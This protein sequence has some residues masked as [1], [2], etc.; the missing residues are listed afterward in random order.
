MAVNKR[1][2]LI[3]FLSFSGLIVLNF[4]I[5]V[6]KNNLLEVKGDSYH[7]YGI[8]GTTTLLYPIFGWIADVY[9]GRY[10]MI[11]RSLWVMWLTAIAF[12]LASFIP[13]DSQHALIRKICTIALFTV[14]SSSLGGLLAN[15][16]QF[17]IDQLPDASSS[18]IISFS[19]WYVWVWHIAIIVVVF[20]QS[21]VCLHYNAL[22]KLL[23]P[24]SLTLTLCLDFILNHWLIKEPALGNPFKLIYQ[25]LCYALK[26]KYPRQR[27]AFT[28]W[29]DKRY[30]RID[31][32]KKKFGG[33][34]TTEEVENVKTF[35]RMIRLFLFSALFVG[36]AVSI[37]SVTLHMQ[38]HLKNQNLF[39]E[40]GS[41]C[42]VK[43]VS[44]CIQ[45]LS[46]V[47]SAHLVAVIFIPLHEFG[48]RFFFRKLQIIAKFNLGLFL[49]LLHAL[50]YLGIEIAGHQEAVNITN[51]VCLL[52]SSE[53]NYGISNV[54]PLN[55]YWIIIPNAIH[56][57]GLFF[58]LSSTVQF[59]CAQSPYSM[60]GL[61]FGI[62]YGFIGASILFSYLVLL[63]LESSIH[64]RLPSTGCGVWYLLSVSIVLL[65]TFLIVCVL[66]WRY[67]KRQRDD[68]QH[69]EHMFAINYYERYLLDKAVE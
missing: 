43:Y 16:L 67:K 1:I 64:K 15:I 26:N 53:E 58:M 32:A 5:V 61:L 14:M 11:R 24:A 47:H 35:G 41:K 7:S 60:K 29:D 45:R 62:G 20:S 49:F 3:F 54:L 65:L 33:P 42:T 18:D 63:P 23:L 10:R 66:S 2:L 30:S 31:L 27:S 4:F 44:E 57:I 69:N 68:M 19:N 13:D 17:G 50:G 48:L 40:N 6:N 34:F 37:I 25:V 12:C 56:G 21:C 52:N 36:F 46:V 39:Q 8:F 28:Y 59:I 22:A 9:W 51:I 38:Y 55:Y